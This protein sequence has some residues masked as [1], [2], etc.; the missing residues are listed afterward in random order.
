[1]LFSLILMITA[2][3]VL[4]FYKNTIV[5]KGVVEPPPA[6]QLYQPIQRNSMWG[7]PIEDVC[8][9][10]AWIKTGACSE[11]GKIKEV[12][13]V[14]GGCS[15][16]VEKERYTDCC[17]EGEWTD[18][19]ACTLEGFKIQNR[20][21]I[22]CDP[23]VNN[24][25]R[26]ECCHVSDWVNEGACT[27]LGKQKQTRRASGNCDDVITTKYVPCCYTSEWEDWSLC[28]GGKKTQRR[29]VNG[30]EPSY[31]NSREVDCVDE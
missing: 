2:M 14:Y 13:N 10:S 28:L 20:T 3:V 21:L 25:R 11:D 1:M 18:S 15:E 5:D 31:K 23:N 29:V 7:G 12:R 8:T 19:G 26:I 30:C 4:A 6:E 24:T 17:Y 27:H 16:S 22:G 9:M